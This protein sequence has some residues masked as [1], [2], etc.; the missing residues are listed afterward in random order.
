MAGTSFLADSPH[1]VKLWARKAHNDSVKTTMYGMLSGSSDRA[2][3]QTR[4]EIKSEGDRIRFRLRMLP[5]GIGVQDAEVLEGTEEGLEYK[6]FDINLGEKRK[7]FK[8]E[9]NLSEQRTKADVRGDMK[10]ALEEWCEEY[11]DTTFFEYLSGVAMG[12]NGASKFHPT[13]PLGGN[14]LF[15]PSTDRII[16]GGNATAANNVDA[17]DVFDLRVL[18]KARERIARV[19]PTM[20]KGKFGGKNLWTCVISPE[21]VTSLRTNTSTGQWLDLQKSAMQGGKV[22]DNP[23][24]NAA[25]GVYN[26]FMLVESTRI[27]I[28]QNFGAGANVQA[29]R[30]LILGAQAA[31]TCHGIKTDDKGR[32]KVVEKEIDYGKHLGLGATFVWG[33]AKSRFNDQSDFGVFAVDTAAAPAV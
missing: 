24:W 16:Y 28:F 21:Q 31:V 8:V 13:G 25:L 9:L 4:D 19:S 10:A 33:M 6:H 30:A 22:D 20:R 23:I 15:P 2:I 1:A 12:L 5:T 14:A 17:T 7:A 18:D 27:P 3:V 29:H 11:Y 32:L 26:D